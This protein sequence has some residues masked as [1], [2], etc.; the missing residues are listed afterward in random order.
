MARTA[1]VRTAYSNDAVVTTPERLITMLYDRLVRD[2]VSAE[3]AVERDDHVVSHEVLVHAQEIVFELLSALDVDAW[4]GGEALASL[5]TWLLRQLVEA[6]TTKD[7][8][9]IAHCRS[10]VGPLAE[11]WHVAANEVSTNAFGAAV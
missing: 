7:A 4:E 11:A 5:Y 6:N 1:A 9:K 10:L 3:A 2:L 8:A